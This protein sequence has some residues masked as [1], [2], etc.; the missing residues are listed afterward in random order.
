MII[1][2]ANKEGIKIQERN[3]SN[4]ELYTADEVFTSGTMGEITPILEADGR[5]IG[6]GTQGSI[7]KKIQSLHSDYAF[8]NGEPVPFSKPE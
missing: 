6:D 5:K 2:I 1:D 4:S 3:I 8:K 7:T